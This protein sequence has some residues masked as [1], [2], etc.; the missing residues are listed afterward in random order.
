MVETVTVKDKSGKPVEG[1]TANDFQVTED[2]AL[3]TIRF[4]EHHALPAAS[5]PLASFY[6]VRDAIQ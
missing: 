3:E 5:E 6:S 2:N 4:F 1:L